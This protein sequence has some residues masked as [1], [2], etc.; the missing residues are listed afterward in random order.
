[1]LKP[2]LENERR[3]SVER[4]RPSPAWRCRSVCGRSRS[5]RCSRHGR[6]LSCLN[7]SRP[8]GKPSRRRAAWATTQ[9]LGN[10]TRTMQ[11]LQPQRIPLRFRRVVPTIRRRHHTPQLLRAE[12]RRA[13]DALGISRNRTS[14][15]TQ[16]RSRYCCYYW[17][18]RAFR[19]RFVSDD[20]R[21]APDCVRA[22]TVQTPD[23][24]QLN[25]DREALSD[26][27]DDGEEADSL[28]PRPAAAPE[29]DDSTTWVDVGEDDRVQITTTDPH[30]LAGLEISIPDRAWPDWADA[31]PSSVTR[32]T[33]IGP[34]VSSPSQYAVDAQGH[35][36]LF[37]RVDILRFLGASKRAQV[38]R[39]KRRRS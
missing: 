14:A 15:P 24:M 31:A 5:T 35:L 8:T 12:L 1:M 7:S 38:Q 26:D 23:Q 28:S 29:T 9:V 37:S 11:W 30:C 19:R 32:C 16:S 13:L 17:V 6:S 25:L 36:Y 21:R 20:R 27:D 22:T 4:W 10:R 3:V 34:T 39:R 2:R 18:R 33:I